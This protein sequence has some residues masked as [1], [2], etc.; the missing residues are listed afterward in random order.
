MK[1][2]NLFGFHW[3]PHYLKENSI[4]NDRI[5]F[6]SLEMAPRCQAKCLYC[7]SGPEI[8]KPVNRPL[9][10]EEYK[11]IISK[12]KRLGVKT[13][14]F[15]GAG[16]PTL[17]AN[18]SPMIEYAS[19]LGIVS[20]VYT[21][22]LLDKK[23]VRFFRS[24]NVSLIIKIDSLCRRNYE[25]IVGLSCYRRFVKALRYICACYKNTVFGNNGRVITLLAANTV[26][27]SINKQEIDRISDFCV[28]HDILHC[29]ATVSKVGWAKDNWDV[30]VGNSPEELV[31]IASKCKNWVSSATADGRCGPFA[32]GI[33]IDVNGD[34]LGCPSARWIRLANIRD[35]SLDE[36]IRIYKSEIHSQE[37]H[38]CLARELTTA[39]AKRWSRWAL[40][41]K[42]LVMT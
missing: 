38:Y 16:E 18:L 40:C 21:N 5:T 2:M 19:G 7:F 17:D 11:N 4:L 3:T 14:V 13:I 42:N 12:S 41:S 37:L 35:R 27:T 29:V 28:Q 34:V 30:L 31:E 22:G 10:L 6:L 33:T 25:K 15:P 39:A 36:V 26:V 23:M 9:S 20:V 32:H 24:H 1:T 8:N